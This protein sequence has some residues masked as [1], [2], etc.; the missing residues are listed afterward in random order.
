[1]VSDRALNNQLHGELLTVD[2]RGPDAVLET[3]AVLQRL[4]PEF[5]FDV[6][7]RALL[8]PMSDISPGMRELSV[9]KPTHIKYFLGGAAPDNSR[10]YTIWGH[11]YSQ[12]MP[13]R[14]PFIED[15]HNHR[16][17]FASIQLGEPGEGFV[18]DR[19]V[20][21][22]DQP[23]RIAE[24]FW[25]PKDGEWQ[26]VVTKKY[27]PG[28]TMVIRGRWDIHRVYDIGAALTFLVHGPRQRDE[29]QVFRDGAMMTYPNFREQDFRAVSHLRQRLGMP[30]VPRA[31]FMRRFHYH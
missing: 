29:T 22:Y 28:D 5:L 1:M 3:E 16:G 9:R 24:G 27:E 25:L 26:N 2:W 30:A 19:L 4:G 11:D 18:E 6:V 8:D 20:A 31:D 23:D 7:A 12:P 21:P 15:L 13:S 17:D 14:G 10:G